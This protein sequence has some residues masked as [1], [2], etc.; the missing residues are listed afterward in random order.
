MGTLPRRSLVTVACV[1]LAACAS[2]VGVYAFVADYEGTVDR[3]RDRAASEHEPDE[4]LER[5]APEELSESELLEVVEQLEAAD[6]H[7]S[8]N[9]LCMV[10]EQSAAEFRDEA[11]S[12][13]ESLHERLVL[14]F[15]AW[16]VLR[17]AQREARECRE[18]AGS[19]PS[20]TSETLFARFGSKLVRSRQR[21]VAALKTADC[22]EE[23]DA[24]LS[25]LRAG[26]NVDEAFQEANR[27]EPV[28]G[29]YGTA[30]RVM[31]M[32]VMNEACGNSIYADVF[33]FVTTLDG[34]ERV[35]R[36]SRI[37][38]AALRAIDEGDATIHRRETFHRTESWLHCNEPVP[39]VREGV[40][41]CR[42]KLAHWVRASLQR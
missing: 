31:T 19:G 13:A 17:Y 32:C 33:A 6:E 9:W 38:R 25:A 30:R 22:E 2:V 34:T 5:Y 42:P 1:V 41:S 3:L 29:E 8:F 37:A 10:N 35:A 27:F 23:H 12:E 18:A 11:L 14:T 15:G 21:I 40:A 28:V 36:S 16:K 20:A 26:A 7:T 24:I 39:G 4:L